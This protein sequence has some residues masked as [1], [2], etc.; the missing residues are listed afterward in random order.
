MRYADHDKQRGGRHPRNKLAMLFL[1]FIDYFLQEFDTRFSAMTR[2]DML[3]LKL[4]PNTVG[5]LPNTVGKLTYDNITKLQECYYHDLSSPASMSA[6]IKLWKKK[7]DSSEKNKAPQS[8]GNNECN[9]QLHVPKS[10]LFH[11]NW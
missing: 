4:L 8:T 9:V 6:E 2:K 10:V 5:K 1:P 7:W 11:S 3:G